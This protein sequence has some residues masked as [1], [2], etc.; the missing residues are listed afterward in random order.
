MAKV[1]FTVDDGVTWVEADGLRVCVPAQQI[2][3]ADIPEGELVFNFT[4][5]GV[6]VDVWRD[7]GEQSINEGTSSEMYDEMVN[8]LCEDNS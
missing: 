5:E 7:D 2:P 8:R 3:G 4:H 1:L 6:I